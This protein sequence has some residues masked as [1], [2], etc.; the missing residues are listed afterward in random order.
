MNK[1]NMSFFNAYLELDKICAQRLEINRG[2]VSAYIG[3]LVELRFAP[4]RS[5]V[6]P[7]LLKYRKLRNRYFY[8]DDNFV[9]RPARSAQEIVMEGRLLH[10]CVGGDRYLEKH[11]RGE[12]FIL[13]LRKKEDSEVPYITVEIEGT[14]MIQWYGAYD[15]KPEKEEM[16]KWLSQYIQWLE[17]HLSAKEKK[18]G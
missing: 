8:E 14:K 13:M 10:H 12:S 5:E 3:R 11:H 18:A 9:I 6:L 1:I 17:Q 2:G 15:K 7:R 16:E 4:N